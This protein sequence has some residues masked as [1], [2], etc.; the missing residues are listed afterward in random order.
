MQIETADPPHLAIMHAL[1]QAV[2]NAVYF[3]GDFAELQQ[4]K[5]AIDSYKRYC[6]GT[7]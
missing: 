7:K 6:E 5:D 2:E 1:A 3:K 4:A